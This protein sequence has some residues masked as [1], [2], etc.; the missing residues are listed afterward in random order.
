MN[1][2]DS[3]NP[4]DAQDPQSQPDPQTFTIQSVAMT[5]SASEDNGGGF[6]PLDSC[7]TPYVPWAP[8]TL[9]KFMFTTN[10]ACRS[11]VDADC[12]CSST[13]TTR[14]LAVNAPAI[15]GN[16]G[17]GDGAWIHTNVQTWTRE[18]QRAISFRSSATFHIDGSTLVYEIH[19]EGGG[20]LETRV[21]WWNSTCVQTF[22]A[23][24]D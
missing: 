18:S 19:D 14:C 23:V 12:P 4:P 10:P 1:G 8:P 20:N 21:P 16:D 13:D 22:T 24:A 5:G 11:D 6:V 15:Y 9:T 17:W 7:T 2:S 3:Q